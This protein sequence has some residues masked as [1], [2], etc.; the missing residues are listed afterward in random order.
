MSDLSPSTSIE[1]DHRSATGLDAATSEALLRALGMIEDLA[2]SDD[3]AIRHDRPVWI[4]SSAEGPSATF[5]TSARGHRSL[6]RLTLVDDEV[7]TFETSLTWT[8]HCDVEAP[9]EGGHDQIVPRVL[10]AIAFWRHQIAAS[11]DLAPRDGIDDDLKTVA[12]AI[13][14]V[15]RDHA[16]AAGAT[17]VQIEPHMPWG[18]PCM[19]VFGPTMTIRPM[20]EAWL[21]GHAFRVPT[22]IDLCA[23]RP[24]NGLHVEL[25][26]SGLRIDYDSVDAL[27]GMRAIRRASL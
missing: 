8:E 6:T 18:R 10:A 13:A 11:T 2:L 22:R 20:D 1:P 19:R 5:E 9:G 15:T 26:R 7:A 23:N 17:H 3:I 24:Q 12:T 4:L 14:A 21:D 16:R 27:E 25:Q